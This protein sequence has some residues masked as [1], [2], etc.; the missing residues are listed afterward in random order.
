M[1][2][3]MIVNIPEK[4]VD[5]AGENEMSITERSNGVVLLRKINKGNQID[6]AIS[7]AIALLIDCNPNLEVAGTLGLPSLES[8]H[9]Q[10]VI[11]KKKNN[12]SIKKSKQTSK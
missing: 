1:K 11:F 5:F 9:S 10:I 7:D 6:Y 12:I 4:L 3:K 8:L 2:R